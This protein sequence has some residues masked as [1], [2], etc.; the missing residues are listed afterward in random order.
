MAGVVYMLCAVTSTLCA[1]LLLRE[2]RRTSSRLLL[3]SGVSFCGLA[4]SNALV[5]VDLVLLGPDRDLSLYRGALF[6][7]ASGLLLFSLIKESD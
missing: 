3:W 4:L 6:C 5:F 2:H 1:T 7:A